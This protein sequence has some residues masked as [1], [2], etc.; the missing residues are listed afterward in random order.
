MIL[1]ETEA[2][3]DYTLPE[4]MKPLNKPPFASL[5]STS[6]TPPNWSSAPLGA[7]RLMIVTWDTTDPNEKKWKKTHVIGMLFN[8]VPR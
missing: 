4:D 7:M 2:M 8:N 1:G 3:V 5:P 6:K